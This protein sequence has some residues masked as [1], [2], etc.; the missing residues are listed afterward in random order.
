MQGIP[1]AVL[2]FWSEELL[3][4]LN[5]DLAYLHL[6]YVDLVGV[7]VQVILMGLLAVMFFL[8]KRYQSTAL[9]TVI[10]LAN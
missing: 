1:L 3:T 5:I 4:L 9:V 10:P 7:S 8:D 6:L 2:L